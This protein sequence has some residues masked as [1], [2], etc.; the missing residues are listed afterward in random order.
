MKTIL[1]NRLFKV[2]IGISAGQY[3]TI[4]IGLLHGPGL[5][6]STLAFHF[7]NILIDPT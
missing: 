2:R 1:T 7:S 5:N 6:Y 3:F 4:N